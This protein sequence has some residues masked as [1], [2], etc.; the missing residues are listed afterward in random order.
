MKSLI[1]L[2]CL[3]LS[4]SALSVQAD[5]SYPVITASPV[6]L[7]SP[8][9]AA[10]PQPMVAVAEPAAPPVWA[11]DMMTTAEKLPVIGPIVTKA[12]LYLGIVSS[13]LTMFCAFL[14]SVLGVLESAF[15]WSKLFTAATA[16]ADFK[17][18]KIMYWIKFFS[19]FNAKKPDPQ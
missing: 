8:A 10:S 7:A 16:I 14:I 11:Q 1:I 5:T 3:I 17:N 2:A 4:L 15:S 18:G 19:M 6:A 13:L 9:P 12:L